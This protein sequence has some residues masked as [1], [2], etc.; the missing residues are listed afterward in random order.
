MGLSVIRIAAVSAASL[1]VIIAV[2]QGVT[3]GGLFDG[4]RPSVAN[5]CDVPIDFH[6]DAVDDRF[7]LD[8]DTVRQ[9]IRDAVAMWEHASAST[10]FRE[11]DDGGMAVR[12][13]YDERQASAQSR[14][15]ERRELERLETTLEDRQEALRRDHE[16]LNENIRAFEQEQSDYNA[17]RRAHE[18]SVAAW[19]AGRIEQTPD[20]RA[21][22]ERERSAL[23]SARAE[24]SEA[25]ATLE[26]RQ[27]QLQARQQ[28]VS[29]K[30]RA[31]NERVAAYNRAAA[32]GVGFQMARY[33]RRGGQRSIQVFRAM[34]ADE[35]RVVLAHEL[36]HAL[37][38]GHVDDPAAVM[39][40]DLSSANAGR[41]DLAPADRAA[42]ADACDISLDGD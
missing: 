35:L 23:Q 25:R 41:T 20:N 38:I 5:D 14:R 39:Y 13:E 1:A 17:R 36:G 10:L 7:D 28:E 34:D 4:A 21:A 9:A 2:D 22:L 29:D 16:A 11:S 31:F 40:A 6:L 3:Q 8:R 42:L 26:Q 30:A 33:E 15:E 19:N 32:D 24:L 18:E 27:E 37:G 12:L